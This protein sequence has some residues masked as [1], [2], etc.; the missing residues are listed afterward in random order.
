M[1]P[2]KTLTRF[3]SAAALAAA[4]LA[5]AAALAHGFKAGAIEI[6]HPWS[7]ATAPGAPVAGGFLKLTNTGA[8]A[9]TLVAATF[10]AANR[11]EIHE[12]AVVDGVMKMRALPA[13]IE[14]KPGATVE[15]KP[16]GYHIMFMD[17]KRGLTKG[18][19][20]KGTLEF[21]KAGKVD[22]EFAVEALA[23]SAPAHG[24]AAMPGM[25]H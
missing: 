17:L 4:L 19:T 14:V 6:G 7:R 20:V 16:G 10:E 21:K 5:P 23:A 22:V 15:L 2:S 9:D 25:K 3:A 13:G 18:E 12:M 11:V 8:E 24:D 1:F